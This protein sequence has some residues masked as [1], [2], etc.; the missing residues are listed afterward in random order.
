MYAV[1]RGA[2]RQGW[3]DRQG[4]QL[5]RC[6]MCGR[7]MTTR[8]SAPFRGYRFPDEVIALAVRHSLRYRLSY[9]DV[10]EWLAERG[11]TVDPSTLYDWVQTF[12]PRFIAAARV[13][14][15]PIGSRWRVD[16]TYR[17]Q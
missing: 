3:M 13:H 12:T 4:R 9:V 8:S 14:R 11:M 17:V 2:I 6:R 16:E 7:R 1:C 10:A 5:H 15:S